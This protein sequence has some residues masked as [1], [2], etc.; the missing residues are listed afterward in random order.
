MSDLNRFI[1]E[2]RGYRYQIIDDPNR[3]E[4]D[5]ANF[6]WHREYIEIGRASCRERV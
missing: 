5:H 6:E 2:A 4:Y 1:A 3:R